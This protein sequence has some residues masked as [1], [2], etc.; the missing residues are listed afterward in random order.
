MLKEIGHWALMGFSIGL[1]FWFAE[2]IVRSAISMAP[3]PRTRP[4][5]KP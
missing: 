2:V 4:Q 3:R 1:G 5:W